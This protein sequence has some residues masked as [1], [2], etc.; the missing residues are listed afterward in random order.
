MRAVVY[1][2]PHDLR[3]EQIPRP[4]VPPNSALLRVGSSSI[5]G[6]DL[7]IYHGAHRMYPAGTTRIPGSRSRR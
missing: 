6:T 3:L 7:R 2:A 4:E 1:H 5:C